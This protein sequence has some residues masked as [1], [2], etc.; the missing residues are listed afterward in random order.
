VAAP[1]TDRHF[2]TGLRW[3]LDRIAAEAAGQRRRARREPG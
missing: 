1:A 3:L 2:H